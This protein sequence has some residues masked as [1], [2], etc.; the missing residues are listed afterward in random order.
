MKYS[1]SKEEKYSLIHLDE[2]KLDSRLSPVL[3]TEVIT[4]HAEGVQNIILD[5]SDVKY[6]DS[7]GLSS[8]LVGNRLFKDEGGVFALACLNDHVKKLVKIS[9]L[10]SVL[11][12]F[13]TVQEAIDAV[14]FNEIERD[15]NSTSE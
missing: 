10:D 13:P 8:L 15:L 9:Q 5:L 1:I 2:E 7:S 6:V 11:E 3:K 12:I 14:F 4:L